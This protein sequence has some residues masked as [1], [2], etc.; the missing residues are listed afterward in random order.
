LAITITERVSKQSSAEQSSALQRAQ[1][2][3][4]S[5]E[6]LQEL[7][8]SMRRIRNIM[9]MSISVSD[10]ITQ[11]NRIEREAQRNIIMEEGRI[12]ELNQLQQSTAA[13]Q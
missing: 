4:V 1:T 7:E 8:R 3:G 9:E 5:Q 2:Q 10:K 12:K 11:L 13:A 6:A